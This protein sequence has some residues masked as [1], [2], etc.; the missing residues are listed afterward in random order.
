MNRKNRVCSQLGIEHPV[1]QGPF[2]GGLSTP[3]LVAAVSDAGGL[4]SYGAH[5]L[6]PD[7]IV[8]LGVELRALTDKPFALNLWVTDRDPEMDGLTKRA[9]EERV[10]YC[11]DIYRKFAVPPPRWPGPPGLEFERQVEAVLSVAPKVFSFVFGIPS[12]SILKECAKRGIVTVGAATTLQEAQA[13]EDAGVDMVVASGFEAGGHRPSFIRR[14]EDS[15]TGT[16]ALVPAVRERVKIP[17]IAAGG[18]ADSRGVSAAFALGAEAA[19]VGTAFLAC[20]ESGAHPA[21]KAMLLADTEGRTVLSRAYTGR[22]ARFFP[23]AFIDRFGGEDCAPLPFPAQG[24]L[25][26]PI[27][28]AAASIADREWMSLYAGQAAPLLH[29]RSVKELMQ[30]LC[31]YALPL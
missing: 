3:K 20:D 23:N 30:E 5:I 4:G 13:I 31:S 12:R 22:L 1:I 6:E 21:H 15:L 9:F 29:H 11:S 24:W 8:S 18:I 16:L 10:G 2:G 19:Q 28:E 17:L 27:K 26:S 25:A 14:A 7:Q